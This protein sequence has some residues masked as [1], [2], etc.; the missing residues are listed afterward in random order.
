M[1]YNGIY[2]TGEKSSEVN[3]LSCTLVKNNCARTKW[4]KDMV[5]AH[6]K[7]DPG[8]VDV[9]WSQYESRM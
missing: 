5:P 4:G 9:R 7:E 2:P 8:R 6:S 1:N 3:T